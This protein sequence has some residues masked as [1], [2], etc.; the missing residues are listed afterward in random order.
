MLF[1]TK[2]LK[3]GD[4]MFKKINRTVTLEVILLLFLLFNSFVFKITN[5]YVFIGILAFVLVLMVLLTGRER[6]NF[7]YKKDV[8]LAIITTLLV[9]YFITYFLGLFFGFVRTA[10]SLAPF[11]ILRNMFPFILIIVAQELLRYTIYS[12]PNQSIIAVIL[13]YVIF[14]MLDVNLAIHLYNIGTYLGITKMICLVIFPSITK[15]ILLTYI[16]KSVG[17]E[18][19]MFYLAITQLSK[20]VFP[21]FPDFGQYLN[22]IIETVLPIILVARLNNMFNY[23]ESR[24]ISGSRY[25]KKQ[26]VLYSIITF[27]LFVIV[28]LTSGL[29]KYQ[30]LTIGSDSM[31]PV[32]QKGDVVIVKSVKKDHMSSVKKGDILVYNHD[33]RIIVHRVQKILKVKGNIKFS[34]KGDNNETKDSWFVEPEDVIGTV[35]FKIKFI[36][37]PTVA[38]NELLN[39]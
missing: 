9:Y 10:Y 25:G 5:I 31:F 26:L 1:N 2:V 36:G 13:G 22:V 6:N 17:Y 35:S 38:L 8:F 4:N 14:V 23:Y 3:S 39:R 11:N 32:I 12:K 20:F 37:M 15:N 16:T 34:T 33:D 21:I 24:K 18:N 30:A 29:F 28:T 7:R 27:L 19:A